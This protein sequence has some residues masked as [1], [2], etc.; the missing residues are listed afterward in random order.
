ML[1]PNRPV[2]WQPWKQIVSIK[3]YEEILERRGSQRPARQMME[4]LTDVLYDDPPYLQEEQVKGNPFFVQQ[5]LETVL[6]GR[7]G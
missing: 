3:H 6:D 1:G 5:L 7:H 2:T 4:V